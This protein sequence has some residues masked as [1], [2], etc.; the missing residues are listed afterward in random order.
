MMP[1]AASVPEETP[2]PGVGVSILDLAGDSLRDR[3]ALIRDSPLE[4]YSS[5]EYDPLREHLVG[6]LGVSALMFVDTGDGF[7]R[8]SLRH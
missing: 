5:P 7:F 6:L 3:L 2:P 1:G 8:H 4:D